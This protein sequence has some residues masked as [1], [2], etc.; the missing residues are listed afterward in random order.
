M[1]LLFAA[2]L[3]VPLLLTSFVPA[4]P[5]KLGIKLG[6]D[7]AAWQVAPYQGGKLDAVA[8]DADGRPA[9]SVGPNGLV[10][11]TAAA[12][13]PDTELVVRFRITLPKGQGSGLAL[14]AGQKKAGEMAA[15]PLGL[16]LYV[17]PNPEPE[18]VTWTLAA[19]PGEKQGTAGNYV[20][21][22][23]PVNRLLLPELTRRRIEQDFAAE[24]TLTKRWLT[25]RYELRKNAARVWLDGR[26]LR[27]ARHPEIDTAGFIRINFWNGSQVAEVAL[28]P[29]PPED[30]RFESVGLDHDLNTSQFKGEAV[31]R[32]ALP[33]AGKPVTVGGVPFVLPPT[34]EKGRTHI[35]L[36]PSWLPCGLVEG[37]FDPAYGD[38]ARWQGATHRNPGRIQFRVPNGQ[39]T[40]L[41]LLAAFTGEAD[42]T[43][44][45]TAQFYRPYAGHPVNFAGK[46]PAFTAASPNVVPL[47]LPN[48]AKGNLHLVTIPLEPNGP[49]AFSNQPYLEFELTKEVRIYRAFPDPHYYSLHAAGLPS[50]VHVFGVT[51]ERAA[52]VVDFQ[53]DQVGHI[54]TAPAKPGYTVKLKN[55][56]QKPQTVELQLLT[57]SHDGSEKTDAKKTISLAAGASEAVKLPV[58]LKRYGHHDVVLKIRNGGE[59]RTQTRSLAFLHPDTRERGDW[60]EGKGLIFGMWDW[61]GGH[62][63]I[64]GL[65]RLKVLAQAG[66]ESSMSP[67]AHLPLEDQKYLES[68][69][70]KSFFLAYQLSMNKTT[71]GGVEWDPKKPA[72]MQAAL[73]KW[74][75]TQPY[76]K[77]SKINDPELAVFF[78]EPLLGPISYMSLPQ[79]Y[80]EPEYQMTPEEKAAYQRFRDQFVI[81]AQAIKKEWPNAKC[82]MP[83]GIPNFPIPFLKDKEVLDLMDG[84]AIDQVLFERMPEMQLHQVTFSSAMWQLKQEWGK[85]GKPWPKLI[86]IEGPGTSPAR[87]GAVTALE[88]ADHTVRA[89]FILASYNTTRFLG[90]PGASHCAGYWGE[91]HYGSGL[92]E[93]LPLLN[94]RPVY[95]SYATMTR[96]LN[97]MNFVKVVPTP[98]NTVFCMQFKHYKTGEL[99]HVLWTL[100]GTRPA[101]I[102]VPAGAAVTAFDSMDNDVL[103]SGGRKPP[104]GKLTLTLGTSPVYVRGLT[105][106]AKVTLGAPEHSDAKPG[107]NAAPLADLGDGSWKLSTE[108]DLDY[109]NNHPEFIRRFPGQ[110]SLHPATG[111]DGKGKAL[112]VRLEKQPKERQTMPFY[113]TL[114]PPKPIVITGKASHVGLWVK[115]ASDWGR[116]VYCFRDAKG[117]RWLSIGKKDEWNVDDTHNWSAFNYDGWRY[118][119]FELPANSPYDLYREM[120]TSFWGNYPPPGAKDPKA[121]REEGDHDM[122]V[123]LP[124]TLEKVIVERRTHVIHATELLP[125]SPDDILLGSL[126]AEYESPADKT[127]EAVRLSRLRMPLPATAPNLAN[128]IGTL[129]DAGT[130]DGPTVTKI[131]PPEREYDGRRCH[132][133]FDPAAGAKS[134]DVWVSTYADG[135]GAVMLGKNWAAPGQLLTGLSPNVDLYLFVVAKDAAGKASRP[136]KPFKVNLKDMF[137]QK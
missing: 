117:E 79:Y 2:V 28:R 14:Y 33:A 134:Y 31:K 9:A 110:F 86:T 48:G 25:L 84:P 22:T 37:G 136:G 72:E 96:Q 125:A 118:L 27:E 131:N 128:P 62:V 103:A 90:W 49:A 13:A 35:D 60:A 8:I 18:S 57:T 51:L 85:T 19:L 83:W 80:G 41:H 54:W 99:L 64:G 89:V 7:E 59:E 100:R 43:P 11:T 24:P 121:K 20:S 91:Q 114:V 133:H 26:L 46:V 21:R 95:S 38:L 69:G 17:Y 65:D 109:E 132:V 56:T 70:A 4:Q 36:K 130:T 6:P 105:G 126:V 101:T 124:L 97:R 113:T 81:A 129:T 119:T 1:R 15:N 67:F 50:G 58:E 102:D 47:Q 68:I 92:L 104:V 137:P 106:D 115:A 44:T 5:P 66:V 10:L 32:D 53:P 88:E 3:C 127:E 29:L 61:N 98:S 82:L 93:P 122:V 135:R 111:P 52:V 12:V 112:A 120:G 16:Q 116:V 94:P 42:T 34:D 39:Y 23:M 74:L 71:L 75:K 40:K 73:I 76:T 45:V 30:A 63:T 123:D 107:P 77:P 78:A 55:T 108:R 87:P